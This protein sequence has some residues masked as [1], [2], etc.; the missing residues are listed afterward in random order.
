MAYNRDYLR[1][2]LDNKQKAKMFKRDTGKGTVFFSIKFALNLV[3]FETTRRSY[4]IVGYHELASSI[5]LHLVDL[6]IPAFVI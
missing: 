3:K 1:I 5:P 6:P 4:M 2:I